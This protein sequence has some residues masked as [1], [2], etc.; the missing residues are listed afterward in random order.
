MVEMITEEDIINNQIASY[1][2]YFEGLSFNQEMLTMVGLEEGIFKGRNV[3]SVLNIFLF[4][5]IDDEKAYFKETDLINVEYVKIHPNL[6]E[7]LVLDY[8]DNY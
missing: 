3:E 5:K 7:Q 1:E 2:D 4:E 6:V 8:Y